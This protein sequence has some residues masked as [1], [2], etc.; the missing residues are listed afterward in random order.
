M[1]KKKKRYYGLFI[2]LCIYLFILLGANH[3]IQDSCMLGIELANVYK[4]E[5][6]LEETIDAYYK[7]S[8]PRGR[9]AVTESH[10]A[11]E[12]MHKSRDQVI[13]MMNGISKSIEAQIKKV[14]KKDDSNFTTDDNSNK[15][16]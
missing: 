16:A 9:K 14:N 6:T 13:G 11:A 4:G 1:N 10:Q 3:A 5:K 2:N 8:I 15:E 12:D 7:E